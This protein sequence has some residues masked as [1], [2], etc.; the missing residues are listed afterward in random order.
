MNVRPEGATTGAKAATTS[1][2][3]PLK[4]AR[5][6]FGGTV[7]SEPHGCGARGG[8]DLNVSLA[9]A[10]RRGRPTRTAPAEISEPNEGGPKSSE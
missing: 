5:V 2:E 4:V 9:N 1:S 6:F 3:V 7:P 10:A 8:G